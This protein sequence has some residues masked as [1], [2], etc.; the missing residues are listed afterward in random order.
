MK[1]TDET[2]ARALEMIARE[3]VGKTSSEMGISTVTLYK[4]RAQ[5]RQAK[6]TAQASGETQREEARALLEQIDKDYAD[7]NARLA[8]ENTRLREENARLRQALRAMLG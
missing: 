5:A 2:R 3:G 6:E 8:A 1:H 4:W 7:D